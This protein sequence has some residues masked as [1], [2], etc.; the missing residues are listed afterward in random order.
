MTAK[1]R[2]RLDHKEASPGAIRAMV[3]LEVHINNCG[4]EESLIQLIEMRCS[5]MNGCAHSLDAHAKEA[6]EA[7]VPE[8]KLYLLNA[9][10]E[11]PFYTSKERAALAWA[12][13]VTGISAKGIQDEVYEEMSAHF[14]ERE[15]LDLTI[16]VIAINGW[17]RINIA[18]EG[19]VGL[20]QA[21][22]AAK[23]IASLV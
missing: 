17:N 15:I 21:G 2:K 20:Y 1:A 4:I 11:A 6:R 3:A 14:S 18:F 9:W 19:D 16:A 13:A 10:R 23:I 8:Q 7:G 12:E 22:D 5:Q